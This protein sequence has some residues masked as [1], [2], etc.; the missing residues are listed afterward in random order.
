[1]MKNIPQELKDVVIEGDR[2]RGTQ[3][4]ELIGRTID[5]PIEFRK[6]NGGW[7]IHAATGMGAAR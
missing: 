3:T 6:V 7:R 2:A 5:S 4:I 1:M